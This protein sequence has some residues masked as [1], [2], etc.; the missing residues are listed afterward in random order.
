MPVPKTR[1]RAVNDRRINPDGSYVLYW[2]ICARRAAYNYGLERAADMSRQLGKPL[3]V[4]EALRVD[5]PYASD[6]LHAFIL[7]GMADNQEAF[8][9]KGVRYHPYVERAPG[10][11][12]GL[13]QAM[14]AD[15][16]L[17]VT[18][19]FPAF[20]LPRMVEAAGGKL[21]VRLEA[22]DSCGLLP[23]CAGGHEYNSAHAFRR[24]LQRLLPV[25]LAEPPQADPLEKPLPGKARLAG[26]IT[27]RWSP[28][29]A[30]LLSASPHSLA[31][32]PLDHD[33]APSP[34]PGGPKAASERLAHFVDDGRLRYADGCR[35]PD[36]Q[37]T[38]GLSPYLH[39][40]HISPH[41]VFAEV[42][43]AEGWS[44]GHLG[45]GAQG[46]REGWWGMS[47]G[48]ETFLDQLVTW[49]ELGY[50]FCK[51]RPNDYGQYN[52]LPEWAIQTL[53]KHA[54]DERS[55]V[56]GREILRKAQT[57]DTLWNAAQRQ[58]LRE[59]VIHNY[60]RMLWGKNILAWS[61]SSKLAL[62]AMLE[63]NDRYA[64]DGRDPNSICGIFWVLGRFDHPW[65]ERPVFGKVRYM[66]TA[67]TRRKLRLTEYLEKYKGRGE[68]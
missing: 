65:T 61:S 41:Q 51:Y 32:L 49:R 40:G 12:K 50:N 8:K 48:A 21:K 35:H 54:E 27:K 63:L 26:E 45:S 22:V 38:S 20:F 31:L 68:A 55:Y 64:L 36:A 47:P 66:T 33:V 23:I 59:G 1:I 19:Q 13:L 16:C 52:S 46:R 34:I 29:S 60:L 28:A 10:E 25:H 42:A 7:Q 17:V 30:A 44:P 15:A 4:L 37:A 39:F 5:Y 11:G 67:N 2:M 57:H 6:R 43:E 18:D 14:A 3:V 62:A 58:L 9:Q 53:A 24:I 56:Y